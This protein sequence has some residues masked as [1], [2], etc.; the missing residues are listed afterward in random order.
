MRTFEGSIFVPSLAVSEE[1]D[2]VLFYSI[3]H[4]SFKEVVHSYLPALSLGDG[5]KTEIIIPY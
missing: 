4:E 3:I 1:S 2:S 5:E